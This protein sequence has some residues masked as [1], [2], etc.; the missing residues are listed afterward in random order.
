M[1]N[2]EPPEGLDFFE[3]VRAAL[4]DEDAAEQPSQRADVAAERQL[5]IRAGPG[6]G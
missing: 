2:H 6:C 4:L 1:L 3:Q 5:F